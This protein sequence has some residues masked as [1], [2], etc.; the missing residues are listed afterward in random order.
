MADL[1]HKNI[2]DS[3]LH[4][5]KGVA[6]A[7]LDDVYHADGAGSGVWK[8]LPET[9]Q[10][11]DLRIGRV[12]DVS[13]TAGS[14]SP[15]GLGDANAI[16]IE[17]GAASGTVSDPVM[18]G[19]NGT[20]TINQEGLYRVKVALQFGRSG[21]AGVSHLL[22]RVKVNDVQAGRSV[23]HFLDSADN[24]MYFENDDWIFF[25]AGTTLKFEVMRDSAGNNSGGLVSY[26]A[27]ES[28]NFAPTAA[29][30]IQRFE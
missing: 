14:Q 23:S 29:L 30:R 9:V 4:E 1:Q 21:G 24:T 25:P 20:V 5:P 18:I 22:F 2:P 28:W 26:T 12:L 3:E 11:S 6:S 19:S 13:S 10:P 27:T 8:A 16:Q 7:T 17:F 15:T